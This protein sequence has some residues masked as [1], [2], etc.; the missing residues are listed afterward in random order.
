ME[1]FASD[2]PHIRAVFIYIEEAH[3]VDE[4]PI[5]SEV[6]EHQAKS[7]EDRYAAA[8]KLG[9]S[10]KWML[11]LDSMD[12]EF[13]KAFSPWPFRYYLFDRQGIAR[14][15]AQPIGAALPIGELWEVAETL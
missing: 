15:I 7:L 9:L 8:K 1:Q 5:G 10:D 6:R 3:A 13:S 12:N 2:H 14:V 4:W 11:L